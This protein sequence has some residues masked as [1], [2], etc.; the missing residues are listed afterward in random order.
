MD[1]KEIFQKSIKANK[2]VNIEF[3]SQI[4]IP[5]V[6]RYECEN[7][8]SAERIEYYLHLLAGGSINTTLPFSFTFS[9]MDCC[10]LLYTEQGGGRLTGRGNSIAMT[11]GNLA[12]V[13]CKIPFS[14]QSL[15][16]PWNFKLFFIH[17][18]DLELFSPFLDLVPSS[19]FTVADYSPILHEISNLLSLPVHSNVSELLQM[20]RALTNILFML[21]SSSLKNFSPA[22]AGIPYYLAEMKEHLDNHYEEPFSLKNYEELLKVNKYRLCREFTRAFGDSPLRYLNKKRLKAAKEML[23]TTDLNIQ[24]ISSKVGFENVSHFIN[25]FKK[26]TGITPKIFRQKARQ[27]PAVLHYPSQ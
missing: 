7:T 8:L 9:Q 23:L 26:N 19:V 10:M 3:D 16:L 18:R 24:E 6:Y 14:L 1:F 11:D 5:N 2:M 21:C 25:L 12:L 13:S 27:G 22:Y 20:H 4:L 17:G 15:V